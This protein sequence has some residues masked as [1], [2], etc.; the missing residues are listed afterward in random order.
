MKYFWRF[1]T[2]GSNF[3]VL[4]MMSFCWIQCAITSSLHWGR[5]QMSVKKQLARPLRVRGKLMPQV[6]TC[7]F[8]RALL[9]NE[10]RRI[11]RSDQNR[12]ISGVCSDANAVCCGEARLVDWSTGYE[13]DCTYKWSKWVSL[14]RWLDSALGWGS[15][16]IEGPWSEVATL[17]QWRASWCVLDTCHLAGVWV[18]WCSSTSEGSDLVEWK[19][20]HVCLDAVI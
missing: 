8:L 19:S 2:S 3:C 7:K 20:G 6:E 10:A 11:D 12:W 14:E 18:L 15:W 1:L 9:T 17:P 16:S 5:L 13:W 4:H